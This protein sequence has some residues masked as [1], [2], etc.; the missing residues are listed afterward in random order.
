MKLVQNNNFRVQ[1][2]FFNN[3][4]EKNQN[5]GDH[6]FQLYHSTQVIT[7]LLVLSSSHAFGQLATNN[8]R[9]GRKTIFKMEQQTLKSIHH[10][11]FQAC[12]LCSPSSSSPT[13]VAHPALPP[14]LTAP[15]WQGSLVHSFVNFII[16]KIILSS[17]CSTNGG[18]SDGNCAAGF[19]N[20]NVLKSQNPDCF[21]I[22]YLKIING[23]KYNFSMKL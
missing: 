14:R 10:Y 6:I 16:I 19:G 11:I 4:I 3:W 17:E 8:T 21:R 9:N 5:I 12:F 23:C 18:S 22:I 2:L 20:S 7:S 13:F 15:V 1:G